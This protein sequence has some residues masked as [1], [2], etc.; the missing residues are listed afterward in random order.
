MARGRLEL[1]GSFLLPLLLL[2]LATAGPSLVTAQ[3]QAT[4]P[5]NL[6]TFAARIG[7]N[8]GDEAVRGVAVDS[9]GATYVVVRACRE[10]AAS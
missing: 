3:S 4:P 10:A 9:N 6:P 1:L 5:L 8:T 2:L 7:A